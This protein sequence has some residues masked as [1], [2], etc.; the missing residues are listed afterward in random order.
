MQWPQHP[1]EDVFYVIWWIIAN[2]RSVRLWAQAKRREV[3]HSF[4]YITNTVEIQSWLKVCTF[5]ILVLF[6]SKETEEKTEGWVIVAANFIFAKQE[7]NVRWEKTCFLFKSWRKKHDNLRPVSVRLQRHEY[8]V[9]RSFIHVIKMLYF[10][11]FE[12][13][14]LFYHQVLWGSLNFLGKKKFWHCSELL[15][16]SS[17]TSLSISL[18]LWSKCT[19]NTIPLIL[20]NEIAALHQLRINTNQIPLRRRSDDCQEFSWDWQKNNYNNPRFLYFF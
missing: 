4:A 12:F 3:W 11:H 17:Q 19:F 10:L 16:F 1:P 15:W 6:F 9:N 2:K 14:L 8:E 20:H 18:H 5:C 13:K 7:V